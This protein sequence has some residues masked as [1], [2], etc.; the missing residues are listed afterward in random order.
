[1]LAENRFA[2]MFILQKNI[3]TALLPV[4]IIKRNATGIFKNSEVKI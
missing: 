3:R 1:M 4:D 2:W